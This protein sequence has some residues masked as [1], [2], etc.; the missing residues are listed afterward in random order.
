MANKTQTAAE[1]DSMAIDFSQVKDI[2]GAPVQAVT[3]AV[4]AI[5]DPFAKTVSYTRSP[6][7]QAPTPQPTATSPIPVP[8]QLA[9][10]IDTAYALYP[11]V[12]RGMLESVLMQESSMGQN[13]TNSNADAGNYGYL[14]GITKSGH[15]ADMLKAPQKYAVFQKVPGSQDLSTPQGA[16]GVTGSILAQLIRNN[17][18]GQIPKTP[19]A[20]LELYDKYYKTYAGAKLTDAQKQNFKSWFKY[21]SQQ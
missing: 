11:E 13:A 15:Y 12:P 20:A 18:G 14:S 2:V 3:N 17:Y 8:K 6:I 21:Y 9:P 1:M 16:I 10:H 19:D 4:N 5:S 7:T